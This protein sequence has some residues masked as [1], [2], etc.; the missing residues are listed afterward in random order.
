[1]TTSANVD[2]VRDRP[3]EACNST[4]GSIQLVNSPSALPSTIHRLRNS[5][6]EVQQ[7]KIKR[8]PRPLDSAWNP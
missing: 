5:V 3:A 8:I 7:D 6:L 2:A 1:M 4:D